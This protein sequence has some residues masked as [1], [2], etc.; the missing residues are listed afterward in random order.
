MQKKYNW[1]ILGP[2][3]I[4]HKFA[5]ALSVTENGV[6]YAVGSRDSG[7]AREF[8]DKYGAVEAYGSY[9]EVIGDEQVEVVYIATPHNRHYE[10]T[11]KC[12]EAGKAVLCEKP[13]TINAGQFEEL[14]TLARKKKVF[15]MDALWTRF[16]PT[17]VKA[18]EL[19]DSGRI[20]EIKAVKADFGFR[21]DY[22]PKGRLYNPELGG[23]TILDIGIYPVFLSLLILGYPDTVKAA[24]VIGKTGVDESCS[25]AFSYKNGAVANL[26]STFLAD[27]ETSAEI[28]GTKGK[29]F[30]NRLWFMPSTLTLVTG[31]REKEDFTFETRMNGY[32]YEAEEVMKCL[33]QGKTE[34]GIL[35]LD[36]T[37]Q[38]MKLLDAVRKEV[39]VQYREDGAL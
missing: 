9:D 21:T 25:M 20:G 39:G 35:P 27:T 26:L 17:I 7:R 5:D 32:E 34:S 3:N 4:A 10:L 29:I 12:L 31:D 23:G 14:V 13:I 11:K 1:G 22:N 38:L 6:L 28:C 37:M 16:I 33:D 15:Y 36:F 24:A 8:A 30:I 2:G 19:I 18:K